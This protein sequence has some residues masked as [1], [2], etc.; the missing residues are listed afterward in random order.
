MFVIIVRDSIRGT[1]VHGPFPTRARASAEGLNRYGPNTFR[2]I[3][4]VHPLT[5]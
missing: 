3:W 5:A 2:A 1:R 4:T